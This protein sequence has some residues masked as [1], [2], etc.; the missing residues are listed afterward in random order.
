[1]WTFWRELDTPV[2]TPYLN[3]DCAFLDAKSVDSVTESFYSLVVFP[4]L[5]QVKLVLRYEL[6]ISPHSSSTN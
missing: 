6:D 3:A 5:P 1:M 4:I 2:T